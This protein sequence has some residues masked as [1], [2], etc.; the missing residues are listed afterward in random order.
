M[1]TTNKFKVFE[2]FK[3]DRNSFSIIKTDSFKELKQDFKIKLDAENFIKNNIFFSRRLNQFL[4]I[5]N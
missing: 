2:V 4:T 3:N 5:N 1:E